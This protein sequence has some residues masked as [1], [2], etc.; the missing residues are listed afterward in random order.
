MT[1][2][3]FVG[4]SHRI[5]ALERQIAQL[6]ELERSHRDQLALY[7]DLF[8]RIQ[9]LAAAGMGTETAAGPPGCAQEPR[10]ASPATSGRRA[11]KRPPQRKPGGRRTRA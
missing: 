11:E 8:A 10:S 7:R 3:S 6:H 4:L 9:N 1:P 5:S 2:P